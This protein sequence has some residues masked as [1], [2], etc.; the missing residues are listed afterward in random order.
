MNVASSER[1]Q[2]SLDDLLVIEDDPAFLDYRCA[3]TDI[4]LWP[5]V[6]T[7]MLRMAMSD[8]LYDTPLD[9]SVSRGVPAWR[10]V[11][12]LLRSAV[13]NAGYGLSGRSR[14]E[15]C[16]ISPGVANQMVDG[17][18]LNRLADHFALLLPERTLCV[19]EHFHWRWPF[20]RHAERVMLHAP[21]QARNQLAARVDV[22]ARHRAL[23]GE[24][25]QHA[26]SRARQRLDWEPG[27]RRER[28]LVDMLA[29]K[30][31]GMPSQLRSYERL[32]ARVRPRLLLVIAAC[33]GPSAAL[34]VAARRR[35]IAT[36]EYQH[37]V[38]SV[39][40]DGYNYA[41]S[42]A[43][44]AELQATMPEH[45]LGYGAWWNQQF[46]AP[47]RKWVV[48]N[49]HRQFKLDALGAWAGERRTLLVLSDG[50]EFGIYL[51]LAR[52]LEAAAARHRLQIVIRPHPLERAAVIARYGEQWGDVRLDSNADLYD[53]LRTAHV[54]VSE[55][56]TGLF[57][58]AG[59]ADRLFLWSTA[60]SRFSFRTP[61]FQSFA[62]ADELAMLLDD[63]AAGRMPASAV[64]SVWASDWRSRYLQF[65][66]QCGVELP[67]P[68]AVAGV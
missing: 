7:V 19:E 34:I 21:I 54:V 10:A 31:A 55:L 59:I 39:G 61:P 5:Q 27:V 67:A 64:E 13:R 2:I 68:Q 41:P 16:V 52:Q 33:Y 45:F 60:K 51:D 46:N 66:A 63:A 57:E 1:R 48:G 26:V 9:G 28:V 17:K 8:F 22:R 4:L 43:G 12:T 58:G 38:I 18:W 42:L 25:V 44:S 62:S 3:S 11:S 53:S 32:L 56:S 24:I 47:V 36:G 50:T 14:S 23:A 40:H 65:A 20:P 30:I 6:R 49:P 15:V 29:R 35:G 37:G